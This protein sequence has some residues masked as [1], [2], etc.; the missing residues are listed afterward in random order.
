MNGDGRT[1]VVQLWDNGGSLG[2]IVYSPSSTGSGYEKV[3]RSSDMGEGSNAVAWLAAD[4]NG[5]GRT[6]VVQL[7][8][9]GGSLGMIVYSPLGSGYREVW[10]SSNMGEGSNAVAWLAADMNGDGRTD[11]VQLWDNGGSLG[12]IVYT[13]LAGIPGYGVAWQARNM[14]EES[15]ALA[16]L[17]ARQTVSAEYQTTTGTVYSASSDED[18]FDWTRVEL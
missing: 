10:K 16:W 7:W 8:D 12:M 4:M 9:S 1:D 6:D 18:D 3:W 13:P 5:D 2:M 14:G 15:R 11:V 17:D